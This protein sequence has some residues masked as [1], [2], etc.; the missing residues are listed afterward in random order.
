MRGR[1]RTAF[2][3]RVTV[4]IVL[5]GCRAPI[6]T[7]RIKRTLH[8]QPQPHSRLKRRRAGGRSRACAQICDPTR[9][10]CPCR[11]DFRDLALS[12]A[13]QTG[14]VWDGHNPGTSVD[15]TEH[16]YTRDGDYEVL[17]PSEAAENLQALNNVRM[18]PR[19]SR[20]RAGSTSPTAYRT[21]L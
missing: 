19:R 5:T 20:R 9:T 14:V 3:A 13:Q 21:S 17:I 2:G 11:R 15:F 7:H 6:S 10:A 12:M 18:A 4:A 8:L 1:S 16:Q